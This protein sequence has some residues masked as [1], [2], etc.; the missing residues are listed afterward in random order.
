MLDENFTNKEILQEIK[1]NFILIDMFTANDIVVKYKNVKGTIKEFAKHMGV[2]AY[3]ATLFLDKDKKTIFKSIG[4]R[5]TQEY[6]MELMFIS[7][8]SYH[9]L[10]LEEFTLKTEFERDD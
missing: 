7:S 2:P 1:Q 8:K 3:P 9:Q 10:T 6:L 5:N 4:Y